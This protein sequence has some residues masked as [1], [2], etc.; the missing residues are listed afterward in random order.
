MQRRMYRDSRRWWARA[1]CLLCCS[2]LLSCACRS[3][4][5]RRAPPSRSSAWR[6]AVAQPAAVYRAVLARQFPE[7]FGGRDAAR[8]VV[9]IKQMTVPGISGD[10]DQSGP[11]DYDDFG[12]R[13]HVQMLQSLRQDTFREFLEANAQPRD[14]SRWMRPGPSLRIA[15]VSEIKYLDEAKRRHAS[16]KAWVLLSAVGFSPDA[17]QAL[18]WATFQWGR[19][20]FSGNY[21]LLAWDCGVWRVV[22]HIEAWIT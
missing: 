9:V 14:L 2:L 6:I 11:E 4:A 15:P 20:D 5:L 17:R 8:G 16:A 7:V 3:S 12:N 18:V 22:D 19:H 10:S 1:G 21:Y 13:R